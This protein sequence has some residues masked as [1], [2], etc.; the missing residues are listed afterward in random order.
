MIPR[1]AAGSF[2]LIGLRILNMNCQIFICT[3]N[4]ICAISCT[5]LS[6]GCH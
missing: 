5:E 2:I 4:C 3:V 6:H 1:A